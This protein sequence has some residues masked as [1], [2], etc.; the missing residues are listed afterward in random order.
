M[1]VANISPGDGSKEWTPEWLQKLGHRFGDDGDFWIAYEDLLQK[2]QAF[3]RTRL[4]DDDWSVTQL[5]TT[6]TV[7]WMSDYSDTYFTLQV[8][9]TGPVVIV[10]AQLDDRYFRGLEGEYRYQLAFRIHKAGHDDYLVRTQTPY[11]MTRSINVELELEQG[12]YEIRVKIE[13]E[14]YKWM[15]PIE[16]VVRRNAKTRLVRPNVDCWS[17]M[18]INF[19]E[20]AR[21]LRR[22]DWHTISPISKDR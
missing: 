22:P 8:P 15:L 2:Y 16:D 9:K 10:L 21:N 11:R 17:H 14:R 19:V 18:L 5:W 3:E 13:A 1:R 12:D 4:F 7:P 6:F 20:D